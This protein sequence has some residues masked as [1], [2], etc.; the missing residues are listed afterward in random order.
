[1]AKV[2]GMPHRC[3][4]ALH[5]PAGVSGGAG[6]D[7]LE[8]APV[9]EA[10]I[11]AREQQALRA[12]LPFDSVGPRFERIDEAGREGRDAVLAVLGALDRQPALVGAKETRC[13]AWPVC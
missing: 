3:G 11:G 7:P 8:G 2:V 10:T 6:P 13:A 5:R 12:M 4:L 9:G 1:M